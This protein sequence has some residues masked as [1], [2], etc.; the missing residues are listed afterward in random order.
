MRLRILF[1]HYDDDPRL[2]PNAVLVMDEYMLEDCG[3][4]EWR[5]EARATKEKFGPGSYAEAEVR[6]PDSKALDLFAR[7]EIDGE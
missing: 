5:E 1:H 2:M 6:I 4:E 7:P 3:E